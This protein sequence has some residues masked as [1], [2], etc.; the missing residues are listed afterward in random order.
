MSH[1]KKDIRAWRAKIWARRNRELKSYE[2]AP[3]SCALERHLA[4]LAA[5]EYVQ[6]TK[7]VLECNRKGRKSPHQGRDRFGKKDCVRGA[8]SEGGLRSER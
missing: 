2:G 1:M 7:E 8:L 4:A 5:M 6:K 3:A